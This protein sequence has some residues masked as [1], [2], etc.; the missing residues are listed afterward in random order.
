MDVGTFLLM[1]GVAYALG[2]LWYDLL[3]GRLPE[4][5]WRV[6]A[7]PFLGVFVAEALLPQIITADP[8]FGGLHLISVFV[9]SLV[10]VVIDWIVTGARHP[11]MVP[12]LEPRKT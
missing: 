12:S 8:K 9:G 5:V 4:R 6:A 1:L 11:A 10:A 7:Y 3:L 2:V